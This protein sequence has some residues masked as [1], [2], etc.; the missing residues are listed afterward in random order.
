MKMIFQVHPRALRWI[1][2]GACLFLLNKAA[3]ASEHTLPIEVDTYMD[4]QSPATNYGTSGNVRVLINNNVTSDGSVCRG[5]FQLPADLANFDTNKLARAI[6]YFYVWQNNTSNRY[7]TLFPLTHSFIEGTGN[8]DGATWNTYDGTNAWTTA[9]GDFDTNYPVVGVFGAGNYFRW[10]ITSLLANETARS[11]LLNYG[12]LLQ[13]DEVPIPSSGTFNA[14]FTSSDGTATE[15]PYVQ[16]TMAA[17]VAFSITTD[18]YMDSRSSATNYG[19]AKTVK[20]VINSSDGSICRGLFQ[21]PSE[22]SIYPTD[23][24]AKAVVRFYVWQDNTTNRNVTLFPLTRSFAE[25]TGNG[26]ASGDGATWYTCDGLNAWTNAGGDFDENFPVIGL[27]GPVLNTDNNDR[28][29]TWDITPLLTNDTA[30]TELL[31]YGA[32]LRIDESPVPA[33]GMPRAPFTSSD[34]L[35]YR[36]EYRPQVQVLV[37]PQTAG[38]SQISIEEEALVMN[39]NDCTPYVTNR[40]ERTF[41]LQ[42]ADGWTLVTNLVTSGS[43]THWMES[44]RSEATNVF[45]RITTEE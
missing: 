31:T 5:L 21:L 29:F 37:I 10:D 40:I 27:K 25:G 28:F 6:V 20:T 42:Q 30:R 22:I 17:Q 3:Q 35:S 4:S 38:V 14:P 7:V 16:V 34:D 13:I 32:L 1:F 11:N 44:L 9:G 43:E 23:Q 41:D 2:A 33:S 39:F 19:A 36:S 24:V 18:V 8:G 15:R 12:A 45:Y 26:S